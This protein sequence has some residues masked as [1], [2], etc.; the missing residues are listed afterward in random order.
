[1]NRDE[2]VKS[3]LQEIAKKIKSE[4]PD[5]YGFCLLTFEFGNEKGREMMYVS[6]SNR[7]DIA[8]AM[9]EWIIKTT[10]NFGNDTGKY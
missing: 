4:L 9:V 8:K 10:N 5:G 6:N 3:K 2:E 7:E 1:M